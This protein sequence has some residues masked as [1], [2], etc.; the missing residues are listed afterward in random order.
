M[1]DL[2]PEIK[3][4]FVGYAR[5][6][7]PRE[8]CGLVA[9]VKGK[10]QFYE[11]KN[12]AEDRDDFI[13][14]PEDHIRVEDFVLS[15]A[16]DVVM[17]LHSHPATSSKPSM[18]DL[19][20]CES[21]GL[22][23]GIYSFKTDDWSYLSPTGYKAPLIGRKFKHGVFDCYSALIDW[24]KE[25]LGITL[26]DF[27]RAPKWWERGENLFLENF[28]SAG[29]QQVLDGSIEY[30]DVILVNYGSAVVNHC[31]I[32]IGKDQVF[33]Q[34]MNRLSSREIYGGMLKKNTR[35]VLRYKK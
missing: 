11:C 13:L 9:V 21:S 19:A 5:V 16:G 35:M 34:P 6:E 8:A 14:D 32:Y 2:T 30:G 20:G 15:H 1:I 23:W 33:H 17:V 27:Y 31:A 29:F 28:P 10:Q 24:Y 3:N 4:K 26:K 12:I 7:Y 25:K 22:A 18:V